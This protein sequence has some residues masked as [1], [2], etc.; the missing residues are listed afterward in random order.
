[1]ER[2]PS[3]LWDDIAGIVL[4][5]GSRGGHCEGIASILNVGPM[6]V[7]RAAVARR[8]RLFELSYSGRDN[9]IGGYFQ[10]EHGRSCSNWEQGRSENIKQR[11]NRLECWRRGG[12]GRE[13]RKHQKI[14]AELTALGP[15]RS[16]W[17]YQTNNPISYH[18]QLE[19][20]DPTLTDSAY[21]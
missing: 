13:I 9:D 16:N 3:V 19:H 20:Y 18:I 21:K 8:L 15:D 6:F 12:N 11:I 1:M 5:F 2:H 4:V 14:S 17:L 7:R 10:G